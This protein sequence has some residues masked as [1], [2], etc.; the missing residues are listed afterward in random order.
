MTKTV[1]GVLAE[2]Q[3][4]AFANYFPKSWNVSNTNHQ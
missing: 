4:S 3:A 2:D 1:G